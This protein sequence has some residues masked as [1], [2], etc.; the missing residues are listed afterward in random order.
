MREELAK[1]LYYWVH[2]STATRWEKKELP[3][4]VRVAYRKR[5]D[6][7]LAMVQMHE[8][9]ICQDKS[10]RTKPVSE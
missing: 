5:A 1:K 2:G 8:E 10:T 3:E 9:A 4:T 7:V 6:E